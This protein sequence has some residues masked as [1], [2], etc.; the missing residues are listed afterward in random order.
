MRGAKDR[1]LGRKTDRARGPSVVAYD[2]KRF[3]TEV[4]RGAG[5]GKPN[6]GRELPNKRPPL[7]LFP[8]CL[9]CFPYRRPIIICYPPS[10]NLFI[11]LVFAAALWVTDANIANTAATIAGRRFS[12]GDPRHTGIAMALLWGLFFYLIR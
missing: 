4:R 5:R 1:D 3:V 12:G 6:Q 7:F 8:R 2:P 10:M 9:G 11:A